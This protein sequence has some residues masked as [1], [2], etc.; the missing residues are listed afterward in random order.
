MSILSFHMFKIVFFRLYKD[1]KDQKALLIGILKKIFLIIW[2]WKKNENNFVKGILGTTIPPIKTQKLINVIR[3][4][5]ETL[6]IKQMSIKFFT[7][8]FVKKTPLL[9]LC[10]NF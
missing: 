10:S 7:G 2:V 3:Q 8:A 6:K 1:S 4:K 9:K 5:N